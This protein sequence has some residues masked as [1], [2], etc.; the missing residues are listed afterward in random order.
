MCVCVHSIYVPLYAVSV[1]FSSSS[2]SFQCTIANDTCA[3]AG[4]RT[5]LQ[6]NSVKYEYNGNLFYPM[7]IVTRYSYLYIT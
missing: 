1:Y 5:Y 4:S 7:N 6:Q 2:S 3:V